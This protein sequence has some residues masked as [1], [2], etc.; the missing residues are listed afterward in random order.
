[1]EPSTKAQRK[2][3]IRKRSAIEE[4]RVASLPPDEVLSFSGISL[5]RSQWHELRVMIEKMTNGSSKIGVV[6]TL[7][8]GLRFLPLKPDIDDTVTTL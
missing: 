2:R 5:R 6:R 7:E 1:M 4:I 8:A 3:I